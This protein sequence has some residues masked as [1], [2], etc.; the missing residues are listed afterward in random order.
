MAQEEIKAFRIKETVE[1]EGWKIIRQIF[2]E[3]VKG[4][5]TLKGLESYKQVESRRM[6]K[7]A[8]EEFISTLDTIVM[9]VTLMQ[10][11]EKPESEFLRTRL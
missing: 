11:T 2:E 9:N 7:G 1:T 10:A 6:A 8:L 4:L 5:D 3:Q